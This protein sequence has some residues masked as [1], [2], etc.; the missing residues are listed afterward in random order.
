MR[1]SRATAAAVITASL[2]LTTVIA[3]AATHDRVAPGVRVA[4]VDVSGRTVADVRD[5]V[6]AKAADFAR[7]R[8]S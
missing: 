7:V 8:S 4:G 5:V 1:A 6:T 2:V 3:A